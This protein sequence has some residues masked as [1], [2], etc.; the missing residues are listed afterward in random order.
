[1]RKEKAS[2]IGPHKN[3]EVKIRR[4]KSSI[5]KIYLGK[6]NAPYVAR[7]SFKKTGGSK[8]EKKRFPP[9][10]ENTAARFI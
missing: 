3:G 10:W 8:N 2:L 4:E 1:V 7:A 5:I 6:K 9:P